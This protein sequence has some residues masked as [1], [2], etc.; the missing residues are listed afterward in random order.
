MNIGLPKHGTAGCSKN[1]PETC[2]K[3]NQYSEAQNEMNPI[4]QTAQIM[5]I[6]AG[7]AV[8]RRLLDGPWP[9]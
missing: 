6:V 4:A 2:S 8:R 7:G 9:D 3:Q 5:Q 1:P